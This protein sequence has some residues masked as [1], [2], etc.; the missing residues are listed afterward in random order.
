MTMAAVGYRPQAHPQ[1]ERVRTWLVLFFAV[2][3]AAFMFLSAVIMLVYPGRHTVEEAAE[4]RAGVLA[5]I[6]GRI[7]RDPIT[8]RMVGSP[9]VAFARFVR[10]VS[11][12][13]R[14]APTRGSVVSEERA[15]EANVDAQLVLPSTARERRH[16]R[17]ILNLLNI[18]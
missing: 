2:I 1:N 13:V 3:P 16:A 6:E 14:L 4:L 7:A 17:Y 18:F 9:H 11:A 12:A 10:A 15:V 8:G 5:H